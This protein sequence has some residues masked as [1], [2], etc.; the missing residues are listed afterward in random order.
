MTAK[1]KE[2]KLIVEVEVIQPPRPSTSGKTLIVS[3]TGGFV[4]TEAMI[5][6]QPVSVSL[7]ATIRKDG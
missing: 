1:I 6:G 7:N 5:N 4:A 2:G 3:S